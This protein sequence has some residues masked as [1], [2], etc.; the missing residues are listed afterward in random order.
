M[1]TR[2]MTSLLRRAVYIV[3]AVILTIIIQIPEVMTDVNTVVTTSLALCALLSV[4]TVAVSAF[5]AV[6]G[7]GL[8]R[9]FG[10]AVRLFVVG[11]LFGIST[12]ILFAPTRLPTTGM[13][14]LFSRELYTIALT[15]IGILLI[16]FIVS[17]AVSSSDRPVDQ[18][19]HD[20][21]M[22]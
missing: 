17:K 8:I 18:Y 4:C 11:I 6:P 5:V 14:I 10:T 13:S 1:F 3:T 7:E 16:S 12:V 20:E 22:T 21:V 9:V 2:M 19:Q 15:Q